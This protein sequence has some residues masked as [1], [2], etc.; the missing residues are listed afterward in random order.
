MRKFMMQPKTIHFLLV[1][2]TGTAAYGSDYADFDSEIEVWP[3]LDCIR[4]IV[5]ALL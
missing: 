1:I 4:W 5:E 2:I 3:D